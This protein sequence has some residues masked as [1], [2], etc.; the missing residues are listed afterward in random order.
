MLF[1]S[2]SY[3]NSTSYAGYTYYY[4]VKAICGTNTAANS[5]F[6]AIKER[7]CDCA[8]PVV[9]ISLNKGDP[10]LTWDKVYNADSYTVYRATTANGTYS[11][12]YTTKSASYPNTSAVA[13]KTYYYKVFANC[14][15]SSYATSASSN[16]VHILAK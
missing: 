14:S 3:T 9:K 6:S 7:T 8:A 1:R 15:R 13:G 4:K 10:K 2:T 12:M 16:V 5:E 11:K